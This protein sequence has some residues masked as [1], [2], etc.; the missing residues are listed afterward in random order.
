M[1]LSKID[2]CN[3][4]I[5]RMGGNKLKHIDSLEENKEEARACR[6]LYPQTI[7]R[8][9]RQ[10]EFGFA[11]RQEI[12]ALLR[13]EKDG[14]RAYT[15]PS[16]ALRIW[17]VT[18]VG[19]VNPRSESLPFIIAAGPNRIREIRCSREQVQAHFSVTIEDPGQMDV[20]FTEALAWA[21]AAEL[22][23]A[24]ADDPKRMQF[25]QEQAKIALEEAKTAD[26]NEYA[27]EIG[28]GAYVEARL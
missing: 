8:M 12:L 10:Y 3:M 27:F 21:M 6:V 4:A 26:A 28:P 17:R 25:L 11:Q 23:H 24:V 5:L 9:L 2:I 19:W 15:W 7:K 20:L 1:S 18:P 16:G 14:S 13:Q 22:C